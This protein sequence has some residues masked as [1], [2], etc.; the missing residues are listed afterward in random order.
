MTFFDPETGRLCFEDGLCLEGGMDVREIDPHLRYT[1]PHEAVY[2]LPGLLVEGG[3]LGA[4]CTVDE[5]G[6]HTVRLTV[7]SVTGRQQTPGERQRAFLFERFR[8]SDPCPDTLQTVRIKAAFGKL[9][10][11]TDPV[12]GQA[13]ALLEYR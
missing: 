9:T 4:A 11:Y 3:R 6:L 5:A 7:A 8:L 13:G 2:C 12:T 10:L 1:G